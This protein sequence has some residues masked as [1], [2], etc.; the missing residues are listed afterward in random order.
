MNI[1]SEEEY[2]IAEIPLEGFVMA[3]ISV[4]VILV[5]RAQVSLRAGCY[6]VEATTDAYVAS[7]IE[8]ALKEKVDFRPTVYDVINDAFRNLGIKVLAVKI[9]EIKENTF[10]GQLIIQQKD[11]VLAL[12]SRPSD[13]TAIALRAKAPIY[14]NETLTKERGRYIC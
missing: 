4:D 10:I 13:A 8:K 11:K 9:T 1:P 3:N 7:A 2:P 12:D 5:D 14:I 6:L